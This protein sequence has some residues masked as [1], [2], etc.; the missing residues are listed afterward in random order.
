MQKGKGFEGLLFLI[1][2]SLSA[3]SLLSPHWG[4]YTCGTAR[5]E[6]ILV[7]LEKGLL[8]LGNLFSLKKKYPSK[9]SKREEILQQKKNWK[10]NPPLSLR[11]SVWL[12]GSELQESGLA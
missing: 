10:K 8:S 2:T 9:E 5:E 4:S 7:K 11:P 3:F 1:R 12:S 6:G